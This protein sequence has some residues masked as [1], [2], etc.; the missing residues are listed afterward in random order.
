[1][2]E[3]NRRMLETLVKC[4]AFDSIHENRAQLFA[5]LDKAIHLAQE[6]QRAE[7]ASQTSLFELMDSSDVKATETSLEFPQVRNW[8][9]RERLNQE[10]DA[11]GFYVSGHPLDSS[12]TDSNRINLRHF[13]KL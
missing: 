3:V 1:M 12:W 4:G 6:F 7:D 5:V 13:A 9:K 8:P 10:K 2:N 11:L